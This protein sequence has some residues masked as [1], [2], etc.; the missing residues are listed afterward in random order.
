MNH[1]KK[2]IFDEPKNIKRVL[3]L[4]YACCAVLVVLDFV[5]HRHIMH[6]WEN[7]WAFYPVYGF[8]GCVL[9]VVVATWMRTFLMRDEN[10]YE[11]DNK[12]N[13]D[14]NLNNNQENTTIKA[15]KKNGEQHVDD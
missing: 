3:H 11:K 12:N 15:N 1:K 10:Y 4:L 5:I 9:L 2:Y 13:L 6:R 14:T 7:M 8:V